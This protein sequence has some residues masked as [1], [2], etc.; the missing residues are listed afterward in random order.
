MSWILGIVTGIGLGFACFGGLWLTVKQMMQS[1][2]RG[3]WIA[4]SQ[5]GRLALCS[6]M[7]CALSREG[8]G[9]VFSALGGFWIA[10]WHLIRR[11][12][13]VADGK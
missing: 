8:I 6:L 5:I 4:V 10:R 3:G 12:G 13:V 11:L 1:P 7:F 2:H 9:V